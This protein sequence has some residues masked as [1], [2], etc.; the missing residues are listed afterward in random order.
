MGVLGMNYD[1][2]QYYFIDNEFYFA[3]PKPYG[4]IYEDIE[5]F[6]FFSKAA[7][8]ILPDVDFRPDIIHCHDWQTGLIPVFL[9]DQFPVTMR[10]LPQYEV[11]DDHP[12]P[13]IPGR[14]GCKD[15]SEISQDLPAYYF[16]PDKLEAYGDANYLKGRYRLCRCDYYRK[17]YLCG[18]DQDAV[19]RR[20]HL[21]G[22]LRCQG[23][24]T[25][26]EL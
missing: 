26:A 5:K 9:K 7:L 1:G 23:Q 3:G 12:Q 8:S 13:E 19:L 18:R 20:E 4:N 11:C 22:L 25:C 21:D 14:M 6:A 2:I 24:Q 15:D 17:Q 10:F 16:T